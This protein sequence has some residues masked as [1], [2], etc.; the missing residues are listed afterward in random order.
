VPQRLG[1]AHPCSGRA[2]VGPVG[3][4][5]S[6]ITPRSIPAAGGHR[7]GRRAIGSAAA[8]YAPAR[9]VPE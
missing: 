2:G 7:T 8:P 4:H 3:G 9:G 5:V 6:R 1:Q